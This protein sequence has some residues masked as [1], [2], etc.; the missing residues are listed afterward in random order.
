MYFSKGALN[1]PL[2]GAEI[3]TTEL[4]APK[5]L[6]TSSAVMCLVEQDTIEFVFFVF[7][8]KNDPEIMKKLP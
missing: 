7:F 8:K 6:Y 2:P 1:F 5:S 3:A 4:L